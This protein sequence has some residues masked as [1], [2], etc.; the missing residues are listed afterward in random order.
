MLKKIL[1][2]L[3]LACVLTLP[4]TTMAVGNLNDAG[5]NLTPAAKTAGYSEGNVG[6]ITGQ[7]IN[8]ALQLVGIIFL[9][10]MVYAGYL[11]MTAQGEE[12]QIEKAQKII[13]SA[14]IGLVLTMSAYAITALITK[15][16]SS[17]TQNQ[18]AGQ[19]Q[20]AGPAEIVDNPCWRCL[21]ACAANDNQCRDGCNL[22]HCQNSGA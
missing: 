14:I 1:F 12:S 22:L 11:W 7:I 10:L 18:G 5:K 8:T 13:T 4:T 19:Q 20:E 2:V 21:D 9:G 15:K 3:S 6:N 16:F 17:P